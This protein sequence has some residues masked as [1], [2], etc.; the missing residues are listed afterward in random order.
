MPFYFSSHNDYR[1]QR[2]HLQY[3]LQ[4]ILIIYKKQ[5]RLMN[6]TEG[7]INLILYYKKLKHVECPKYIY[8][9][10]EFEEIFEWL[11]G[12]KYKKKFNYFF[13]GSNL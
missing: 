8:V 2:K 9:Q 11:V 5:Q 7:Q 1:H 4:V 13:T 6:A 3:C 10:E 12:R